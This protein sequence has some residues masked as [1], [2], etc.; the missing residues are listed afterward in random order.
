MILVQIR[1]PPLE[2]MASESK[3]DLLLR[4]M[5][6]NERKREV[7]EKKREEAKE[8]ARKDFSDL[9]KVFEVR[10]PLVE[11]KVEE[12]GASVQT[13]SD[14]VTHIEG[15]IFKQENPQEPTGQE[16]SWLAG[17]RDPSLFTLN[18]SNL[19]SPSSSSATAPVDLSANLPPMTCPK[20]DGNNPQ[21]WKSNCEQYFDVYGILPMHWVKVATLN[22]C[23]NAAFWLQSI[24]SQIAGIT[25]P[26]L[27]ELVCARFTRD[28]QEALI[29]QW[30]HTQQNSSVAEYVEQFDSLMHQLMAYDSALT[31]VYF[32][33]KFVEGL[34]DDIRGVVMVHRP[35]DLD[36]ACSIALL[37]E[38][39]LEGM[40]SVSGKGGNN[41]VYIK[42]AAPRTTTYS[43][44]IPNSKGLTP[45]SPT[46]RKFSKAD[47]TKDDRLASL[48][49]Y[50]R[51]KGLCFVCGERWGRDHKCATSVQLNVVQEL[52][53]A[54]H[55]DLESDQPGTTEFTDDQVENQLMAISQQALWGT[56]SSK[57]IRLRGWVQGTEVLML[58]DSGSTHS[59]IDQQIGQKLAGLTPLP[60]SVNVRVADGSIMQCTHELVDCNWWMQGYD[61]KSTF[62]L[63]PLGSYDIILGMDW[64]E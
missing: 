50:R 8:R 55:S 33:Q 5:E 28:R 27:C 7:A 20:F 44:V 49:A 41:Q 9:K 34:R 51:S 11:K 60:S 30:F 48:K 17:K 10:I 4:T 45:S 63:L 53:E 61:F 36:T 62:K 52:L 29:R 18:R 42:P 15:T 64:L 6:E 31:P 21:M 16:S 59:F 37:Q 57:S 43:S 47:K 35:Q 58:V 12:L 54:L 40:K 14:K 2:V 26:T 1:P 3:L 38:E 46:E 25:W 22:F 39:V 13:L 56:D 19:E 32:V 23:G 24:R